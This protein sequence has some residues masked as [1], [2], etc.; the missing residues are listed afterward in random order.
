[1]RVDTSRR[2]APPGVLAVLLI[3]TAAYIIHGL[4]TDPFGTL[5]TVVL[6]AVCIGLALAMSVV[7]GGY[8]HA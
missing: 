4:L 7:Y 6:I 1:M 5:M 8:N 3:G 2:D